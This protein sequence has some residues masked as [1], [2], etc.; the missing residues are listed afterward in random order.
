MA[1]WVGRQRREADD[2]PDHIAGESWSES[3]L[4]ALGRVQ[5][6]TA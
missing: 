5:R 3:D 2:A 6:P 4:I 1:A